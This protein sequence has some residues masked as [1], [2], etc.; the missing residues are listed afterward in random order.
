MKKSQKQI[1]GSHGLEEWIFLIL[2]LPV[3]QAGCSADSTTSNEP[4]QASE[5]TSPIPAGVDVGVTQPVQEELILQIGLSG[6]VEPFEET[7]LYSRVGGYLE[8]IR[9]DIGDSVKRGQVLAKVLIPEMLDEYHGL[10]AELEGARSDQQNGLAELELQNVEKELA[11]L[12]YDRVRSVREEEPDMMP[13][14][15]EDE[16]RAKFQA[17]GAQE[18][19]IQTRIVQAKSGVKRVAAALKR[20]QTLMEYAEIKAPFSGVVTERF[21]DPGAL[22][23]AGTGSGSARPLLTISQLQR[24]R[25]FFDVPEDKVPQVQVG[26]LA[27]IT[28]DALPGA[29]LEGKVARFAKVLNPETR[30]MRTEVTLRNTERLL[31]PGMHVRVR[32]LLERRAAAILLPA[33]ALRFKE[34]ASFVYVVDGDT[35][36]ETPIETGFDD[37]IR[38][39]VTGGLSGEETV[40]V[41]ARE[42]LSDGVKV[43]TSKWVSKQ[44]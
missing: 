3:L 29:Q 7:I 38:V 28:V 14:Q 15:A 10:E 20:L 4:S 16:A 19:V 33:E 27:E 13:Q 9:V 35:A 22:I 12:T 23:Q 8:S 5:Q 39:E 37:G 36:R 41:T 32:L 43:R 6:N 30:S 2:L 21:V 11:K 40:I 18:K 42:S 24:L 26:D 31:F 25:V 1:L 17:A 34:G 44:G